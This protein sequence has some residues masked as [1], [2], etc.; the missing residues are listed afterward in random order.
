MLNNG[1][2]KSSYN[3][4]TDAYYYETGTYTDNT[5]L[6]LYG[7]RGLTITI[8]LIGKTQ[9]VVTGNT[10]CRVALIKNGVVTT[11]SFYYTGTFDVTNYDYAIIGSIAS[12]SVQN[13]FTVS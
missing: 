10:N 2:I 6:T 4:S 1:Y 13:T 3:D 5:A 12:G 9:L 8:N 11:P 7:N